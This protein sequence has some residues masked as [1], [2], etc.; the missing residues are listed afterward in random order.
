MISGK[1]SKKI[2][3]ESVSEGRNSLGGITEAWSTFSSPFAKVEPLGGKEA[4]FNREMNASNMVKFTINFETGITTKMRISYD[5]RIF[6]ILSK[7]NL[8]ERSKEIEMVCE[9]HI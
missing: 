9:E 3:I 8:N 6:D 2:V 4:F 5:S 1:K 7:I